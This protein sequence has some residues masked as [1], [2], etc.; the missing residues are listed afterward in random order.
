VVGD[1]LGHRHQ[2]AEGQKRVGEQRED[3]DQ[4]DEGDEGAALEEERPDVDLSPEASAAR[5]RSGAGVRG[6]LSGR[7]IHQFW[8][9]ESSSSVASPEAIM[10]SSR[11][12]VAESSSRTIR[13][14]DM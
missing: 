6:G 1:V 11:V 7:G 5:R 8:L 14:L 9:P 4:D 2:I 3:D 13:P 12:A 10:R